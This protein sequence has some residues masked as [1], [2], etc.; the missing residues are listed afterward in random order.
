MGLE[1]LTGDIIS[2]AKSEVDKI[3][4]E[5]YKEAEN[6]EKETEQLRKALQKESEERIEKKKQMIERQ[7]KA[8]LELEKKRLTMNA[9]REILD[10]VFK[11]VEYQIQHMD[12]KKKSV[13]LKKLLEKGKKDLPVHTVYCK[14]EDAKFFKNAHVKSEEMLGGCILENKEAT[15]RID[16]RFESLLE[17][18]KEE[19]LQHMYKLLFA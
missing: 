15:V 9:Q 3:L 2:D 16:F 11:K 12:A 14:K 6:I 10:K 7:V 19:E 13:G 18:C 5:A 17:Q 1:N 4:A 8:S